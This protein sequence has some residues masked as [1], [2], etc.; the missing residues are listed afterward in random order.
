MSKKVTIPNATARQIFELIKTLAVSP[1]TPEQIKK[2]MGLRKIPYNTI[3]GAK[4]LGFIKEVEG[5]LELAEEFR[6]LGKHDFNHPAV[7]KA[8][9][10]RLLEY[11]PFC[12]LMEML[13]IHGGGL[14]KD[15]IVDLLRAELNADW[16]DSSARQYLDRL[17][18]WGEFAGI[19]EVERG[20]VKLCRKYY[21]G[22]I[23]TGTDYIDLDTLKTVFGRYLYDIYTEKNIDSLIKHLNDLEEQAAK[24]GNKRKGN[25]FEK[26]VAGYF[27]ILGFSART[28]TGH[29]EKVVGLSY[30]SKDGGGD[31]GLFV[32]LPVQTRAERY[33]G[34]AIACEAKATSN[35]APKKAIDQ[36]RTFSE[37]IKKMYPNYLVYKVVISNSIGYEPV[38]AREKAYPD[39][40]HFPLAILRSLVELQRDKFQRN[41]K[42]LT[43]FDIIDIFESCIRDGAL[44]ATLEYVLNLIKEK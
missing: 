7:R 44:E 20:F 27:E 38:Y 22:A 34:I 19:L 21:S 16:K 10:K 24:S 9:E 1:K 23:I 33:E 35:G 8:F 3:N 36:V 12:T 30:T 31:V 37:Q 25:I 2:A 40:V 13:D 42:L 41:E 43:P 39:V 11:S 15:C 18:G 5:K 28:I 32:H 17:I 6:D 14:N 26:I 4:V 29:M